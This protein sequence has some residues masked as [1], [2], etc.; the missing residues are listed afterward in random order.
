M[1]VTHYPSLEALAGTDYRCASWWTSVARALD[2]LDERLGLE[3]PA[4]YFR[5]G[6]RVEPVMGAPE[7]SD[8]TRRLQEDHARLTERARRLRRL[9]AEVAG[10]YHQAP[11]VAG[12]LSAL[13]EAEDRYRNRTALLIWDTP[14]RGRGEQ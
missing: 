4:D 11:A 13:S 9:V 7:P 14:A 10:D 2:D 8:H 6:R 5:A 12:E 1:T 3:A